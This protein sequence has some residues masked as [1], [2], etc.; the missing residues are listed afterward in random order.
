[1]AS[2]V[3]DTVFTVTLGGT[4]SFVALSAVPGYES[5]AGR[6]VDGKSYRYRAQSADLL[7]WE[8]GTA[9]ASAGG[10]TFSRVVA[11]SSIGGGVVNFSAPPNVMLSFFAADFL[12]FDDAMALTL[13][14]TAQARSN[15]AAAGL[16]VANT[17]TNTTEATGVGT[18]AAALFAGGV[19]IAKKLFV[20]GAVALS[21]T[22]GV[23]GVATVSAATASTTSS[24]GALVVTGGVG[25]G[26]ALNVGGNTAVTGTLTAQGL[27]KYGAGAG[28]PINSGTGVYA[29][30]N[31]TTSIVARD[32]TNSVE[33]FLQ[34]ASGLVTVGASSN[35]ALAIATNNLSRVGV[36]S[37]GD[38]T[39]SNSTASTTA[40]SGAL[41]VTGGV[42]IG[43]AL[44]ITGN[45]NINTNVVTFNASNGNS[46]IGGTLG[47]NGGFAV[48]T[49]KFT[50]VAASG[51]T[52]VAG[53][54][55]V[56]GAISGS[57]IWSTTATVFA[58]GPQGTGTSAVTI[59]LDAGNGAAAGGRFNFRKNG[60]STCFFGDKAGVT[61]AG[62]SNNFYLSMS[63]FGAA[64]EIDNTTGVTSV[65]GVLN[66][67]SAT[68]TPAG[69]STA[70]RLV[71]GTTSGF[72]IYYGS[73]A[74]TVSAAKGSL[75]LR[76]DGAINARVYVNTDG[77]TTWSAW[78]T[79]T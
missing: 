35:H 38:V 1:M 37:G 45:F 16:A 2:F 54:L 41:V 6:A 10:T 55:S 77:A 65:Y 52:A 51:D 76:S 13:A 63:G 69:G 21:A 42:G 32:S 50:V 49:N 56:T 22:L 79:L 62:T 4:G 61:G 59:F 12:Q 14:Q 9:V 68:A 64:L 74:P 28:T 23:A 33:G 34:A 46:I 44:N 60:V 58:V 5:P 53:A 72:G 47:V 73:G 7:Q 70:A 19:E 29:T 57:G 36:S 67:A 43:G 66:A 26:G 18:T 39:V 15:I 78:N 71:F 17:F 8:T 40:S 30:N 11:S 25:I 27:I 31:G 75:Y 24:N 3:N 20:T 48:N